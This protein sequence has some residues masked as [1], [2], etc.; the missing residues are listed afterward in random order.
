MSK[1]TRETII[2]IANGVGCGGEVI[3]KVSPKFM[4][5][6]QELILITSLYLA[7]IK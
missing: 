7:V 3:E 6:Q 5:L 1:Q 2:I 4:E